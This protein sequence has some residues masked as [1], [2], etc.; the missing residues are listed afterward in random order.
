MK[1]SFG[2]IISIV[3]AS[4]YTRVITLV[5]CKKTN[6]KSMKVMKRAN[7]GLLLSLLIIASLIHC[8]RVCLLWFYE[9]NNNLFNEQ[10]SI[11]LKRSK[12]SWSSQKVRHSYTPA[13]NRV[14]YLSYQPPGGGW[15][16]QRIALENAIIMAKLLNRTLIA[17]PIAPH[18]ETLR[19]KRTRLIPAG[20]QVYNMMRNDVLM[21]I[22]KVIDFDQLRKLLPVVEERKT[23]REFLN[24]FG[25]LTWH[26]V[27]HNGKI[28]FWV[29]NLPDIYKTR[30]W[31]V[32]KTKAVNTKP[33]IIPYYRQIC[34]NDIEEFTKNPARFLVWGI[35]NELSRTEADIIY[36]AEGSL[37]TRNI[38]FM[39]FRKAVQAQ[40]WLRK[41]VKFSKWIVNNVVKIINRIG[42]PF[43]AVHIRRN[44]YKQNRR[45]IYTQDHWIN[46]L[47]ERSALRLSP[48]LYIATDEKNKTWFKPFQEVG[49]K[50]LFADD[51]SD[52]MG[53]S[54]WNS[55]KRKDFIG[56]HE[57]LICIH[58]SI[59]VGS[60]Y[61]TF[62]MF[63]QRMRAENIS[64][65]YFSK[66]YTPKWIGGSI[67][68]KR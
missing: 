1:S 14:K 42:G 67:L 58:A 55:V 56:L 6:Q 48:V 52:V 49:Y 44:D 32:I 26:N 2:L 61:S 16:N 21:P 64:T 40:R 28:G 62:S 5:T 10:A 15:N 41:Y 34:T 43:N 39:D 36:F 68:L 45:Y 51:F 53:S 59:F 60:Y 37:Y 19:I 17:H 24:K 8:L 22:S 66:Y 12:K 4:N 11:K 13:S 9:D 31:S 3:F 65:E 18:D 54:K 63:I 35:Q 46:S 30:A 23:H 29:D 27:C 47:A 7:H 25:H 38:Y 20:Y 50:L 57:Q 33:I